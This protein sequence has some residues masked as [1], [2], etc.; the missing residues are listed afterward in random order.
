MVVSKT[1][2]LLARYLFIYLYEEVIG[3]RERLEMLIILLK[4]N[5]LLYLDVSLALLPSVVSVVVSLTYVVSVFLIISASLVINVLSLIPCSLKVVALVTIVVFPPIVVES[6]VPVV[7]G[8]SLC[9]KV[10]LPAYVKVTLAD[11]SGIVKL[12]LYPSMLLM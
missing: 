3:C 5:N 10:E 2:V 12:P 8:E 11:V 9:I 1:W 6:I 7:N 4:F